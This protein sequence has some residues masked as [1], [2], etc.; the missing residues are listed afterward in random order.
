MAVFEESWGEAGAYR[1][2]GIDGA[3]SSYP[4]DVNGWASANG[5]RT[6]PEVAE[7]L[8]QW[9]EIAPGGGAETRA[10]SDYGATCKSR[11]LQGCSDALPVGCT[12]TKLRCCASGDCGVEPLT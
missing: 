7:R 11:A 5:D 2:G 4:A 1:V 9:G 12:L 3:E 8:M 6:H 10:A